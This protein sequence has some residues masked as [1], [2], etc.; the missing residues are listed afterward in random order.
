MTQEK[1][2]R[3]TTVSERLNCSISY[4]YRLID[5]G[6]LK[7]FRIGFKKGIRVYPSDIEDYLYRRNLQN[8][9]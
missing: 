3:V 7:S 4:V 5:M 2:L 1:P 9:N 6:E 8:I